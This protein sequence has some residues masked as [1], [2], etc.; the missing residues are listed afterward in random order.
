MKVVCTAVLL[1][2]RN[3]KESHAVPKGTARSR[4]FHSF[5]SR[6][7]LGPT[8]P[9]IQWILEALSLGVKWPGRDADHSP[10]S[11]AKVKNAWS[12]KSTPQYV[13]MACCLVKHKDNFA[14]TFYSMLSS[15][16]SLLVHKTSKSDKDV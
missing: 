6:T 5:M 12:Y 9:P 14:F 7:A 15:V 4:C 1:T 8:Q 2:V 16:L 10:L 11:S 13:F 3:T